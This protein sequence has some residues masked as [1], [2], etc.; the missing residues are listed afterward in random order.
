M[1]T[2]LRRAPSAGERRNPGGGETRGGSPRLRGAVQP[3]HAPE[4]FLG[5]LERVPESVERVDPK[6]LFLA[7]ADVCILNEMA[8]GA[9]AA[10]SPV[11]EWHR[12]AGAENTAIRVGFDP[13]PFAAMFNH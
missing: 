5:S 3:F 13:R 6:H 4:P 10:T 11:C 8:S 9:P 2:G 12:M 1:G 7:G